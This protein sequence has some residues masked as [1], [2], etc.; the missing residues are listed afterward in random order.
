MTIITSWRRKTRLKNQKPNGRKAPAQEPT[1]PSFVVAGTETSKIRVQI[2]YRIIEL[3]SQGLYRSPTKAIEELVSNAYDAGA[4]KVH[5]AIDPDLFPA[6]ATIAV[7]DNGSGMDEAGLR[8]H[9]LIGVSNKRQDVMTAPTGRSQIGRFG[10]GKLATYVLARRLTHIAKCNGKYY[11]TTMNY[12]DIPKGVGG[13]IYAEKPV[14]LPLRELTEAQ[15][16][17]ALD[18]WLGKAKP[19]YEEIKLFGKD[20]EQSWTIAILSDL[21]EMSRELQRGRLRWVLATAMPIRDDFKLFLDGEPITASK[22]QG[23]RLGQW[24]LGKNLQTP[25][26]PAPQELEVTEDHDVD[27]KSPQRFGLTHRQ[28]GRVTGYVELYEDVL[29]GGK[30]SEVGR[31]HGFFVYVRERL[32]NLDDE[33]FGIDSNLLRHGTFSRFRMVVQVDRLD[34]EL[35]SSRET[36]REGPLLEV[37]RNVLNRCLQVRPQ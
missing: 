20:A 4:T 17:E 11:A 28:L 24:V 29:T 27:A 16:K 32:I 1:G 21:K 2:S 5:V 33:Y 14:M 19:A 35:R 23:R 22:L 10:I 13:G 26:D 25:P 9:W 18:H 37:T 8:Q 6:D 30:S 7:I 12:G 34:D 3:F 15:A 36:V 31:S